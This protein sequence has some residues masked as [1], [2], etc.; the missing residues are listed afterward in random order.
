MNRKANTPIAIVILTL[1][2]FAVLGV[3]WFELH[4][5]NRDVTLILQGP[6]LIEKTYSQESQTNLLIQNIVSNAAAKTTQDKL[7]FVENMKSELQ[8]YKI[9]DKYPIEQLARL[10][11]QLTEQNIL[12][13]DGIVSLNLNLKIHE[14][15]K[16]QVL[17]SFQ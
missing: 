16:N 10:E 4:G 13:Q 12:I 17:N 1:A 14:A 7:E 3:A 6:E 11:T 8:K 15:V 2:F 9:N 5:Q